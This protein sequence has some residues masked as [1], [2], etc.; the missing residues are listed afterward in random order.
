MKV[1]FVTPEVYPINRTNEVANFSYYL[2][3]YLNN[4]GIETRIVT[5]RYK[6]SNIKKMQIIGDFGIQMAYKKETCILKSSTVDNMMIYF[7]E[8]Y[9]YFDRDF[10]YAYDDDCERFAFF[11]RAVL[12][13]LKHIDFRP[14]VIHINDWQTAPI[15]MIIN[16]KYREDSFYKDIA[17][18]YTIHNLANQ[19]ICS[20]GFLKLLGT[21]DEVFN[22]EKTEYYNMI[23][24]MKMGI[25][26]SDLITTLSK[27]Y[28]EEILTRDY[29][30]GLNGVLNT[31][32]DELFGIIN[33][34]DYKDYNPKTDKRIFKNY[35][36][37]NFS[38]KKENKYNLQEKLG[39]PQKDVPIIAFIAP[40]LEEKGVELLLECMDEICDKDVQVIIIGVGN[41]V[42]EYSL[43]FAM[44]KYMY[45]VYTL[46]GE[47]KEL[48]RQVFSASDIFLAPY[49]IEPCGVNELVALR[50]G[51][52]LVAK[53]TGCLNE[54]IINADEDKGC[55]YK[56][57]KFTSKDMLVALDKALECYKDKEKWEQLVNRTLKLNFSWKKTATNYKK[58][59]EKAIKNRKEFCKKGS[60][61]E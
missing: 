52:I 47:D 11:S 19:G 32:K 3:Q 6:N 37:K 2:P 55:G 23:N 21:D 56:F 17:V 39:L 16:E 43:K 58:V 38:N 50:Y 61:D 9:Q 26:Y 34:I 60:E 31:R 10:M 41:A 59:Y 36:E 45:Q 42:Y 18:V 14:D 51:A 20:K 7:I 57:D 27:T 22:I 15:S 25:V 53:K 54:I 40:L 29:G 49:R 1:L 30:N 24:Y 46:I 28:A 5:P 12:E 35:S 48:E 4:Q 44:S 33:G 8:N 13:M